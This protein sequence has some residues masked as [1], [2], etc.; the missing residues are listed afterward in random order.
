MRRLQAVALC[1]VALSPA[2]ASAGGEDDLWGAVFDLATPAKEQAAA[3]ALRRGGLPAAKALLRA[4]RADGERTS[5][6]SAGRQRGCWVTLDTFHFGFMKLDGVGEKATVLAMEL[7]AADRA[8][9][10][11]LLTSPS[12]FERAVAILAVAKDPARLT[13]ALKATREDADPLV[14]AAAAAVGRCS[15]GPTPDPK[16]DLGAEL[17]R[18]DE[19]QERL[20]AVSH[21]DAPGF[22]AAAYLDGLVSGRYAIAGWTRSNDIFTVTVRRDGSESASLAPACALA[23]YDAA[24]ARGKWLHGLVVP[25]AQELVVPLAEREQ[26]AA[27][28]VRD[29]DRYEEQE[30]N[31]IAAKL[32]NAG[33][34]VKYRVTYDEK[35]LFAQEDL[36]EAAVRQ[37]QGEAGEVLHQALACPESLVDHRTHLYGYLPGRQSADRVAAIA[38][39]CPRSRQQA[40]AALLRL[41]DPRAIAH[42]EPVFEARDIFETEIER[43]IREVRTPAVIAELKR[44][45][46]AKV[47]RASEILGRMQRDGLLR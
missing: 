43:A 37:D 18:V 28:A 10:A 24:A 4:A 3:Q 5:L 12:G 1:L 33:F 46:G 15:G 39:Q 13:E 2:V 9:G 26:A 45:A 8:I 47:E 7:A 19:K 22:V 34:R 30:R 41:G 27:R 42:L 6:S 38:E 32:V 17:K 21:C 44:L 20:R 31:R 14:V 25:I 16:S 23:V 36:V 11:A 40:V 35:S 29:L